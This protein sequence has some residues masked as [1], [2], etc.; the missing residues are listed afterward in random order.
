[1][2]ARRAA[3]FSVEADLSPDAEDLVRAALE[4]ADRGDS[5]DLT[6]AEAEHYYET[7][8]LPQRVQQRGERWAQ[9]CL[10]SRR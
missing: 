10:A 8:E 4:S 3:A 2:T 6:S 1:V 7:G 5:T 9:R